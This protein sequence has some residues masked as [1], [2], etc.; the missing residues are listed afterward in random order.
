[1]KDTVESGCIPQ[2]CRVSGGFGNKYIR[3]TAGFVIK[4]QYDVNGTGLF[5]ST[6]V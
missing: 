1:M 6:P 3:A 5:S 2:R 4:T